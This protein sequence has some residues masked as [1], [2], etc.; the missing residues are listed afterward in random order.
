MSLNRRAVITTGAAAACLG[1]G[2]AHAATHKVTVITATSKWSPDT[3]SIKTGDTV[4]WTNTAPIPHIVCF[5]KEKSKTPD[6]IS[7]PAG[8]AEFESPS[9]K[10][11]EK[12]SYKFTKAGEYRYTCRLHENMQMFGAIN[13]A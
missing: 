6:K 2:Q 12:F 1:A 5:K 3:L 10:R 7:L 11:G 9:L 8:V 13:V 4:E